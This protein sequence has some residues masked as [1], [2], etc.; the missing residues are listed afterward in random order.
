MPTTRSRSTALLVID[1]Q[2]SFRERSYFDESGLPAFFERCAT[3]IDGFLDAGLPVVRIL[4]VEDDGP[5][6]KAS[7]LAV[8]M[9]ELAYAP[10]ATFEKNVHSAMIGTA[11]PGWLTTRGISRLAIAGIR[12]EQC[13]ETTT[14][15]AA[16]LG[17]A[18]DYVTEATLTF[19]M[20]TR[21]GRRVSTDEIR[22]RTELVLADRFATIATAAE[23]VGR[24]RATAMGMDADGR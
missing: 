10:T 16:D 3:L 1:V 14:R 11:L 19:P 7:G 24:A 13:C 12:T 22:E 23:A 17:F 5:F 15:H 6:S 20:T 9:T 4:H 2:R 18:V 8:P 21:A